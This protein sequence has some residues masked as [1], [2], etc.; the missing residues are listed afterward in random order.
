MDE[1]DQII[2]EETWDPRDEGKWIIKEIPEGKEI[3]GVYCNTTEKHCISKFGF[4]LWTPND[5]AR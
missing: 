5:R 3:I 1:N 2:L 4:I